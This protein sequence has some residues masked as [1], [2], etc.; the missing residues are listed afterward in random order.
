MVIYDLVKWVLL[1]GVAL[2]LGSCADYPTEAIPQVP[3]KASAPEFYSPAPAARTSIAPGDK[4]NIGSYFHPDLKQAVTVRPDGRV[5]LLLVGTVIAADKTPEF[6]AKELARAYGRYVENAEITVNVEESAALVV[7]VGGEV[8]KPT[9]LPIKGEL[10]LLQSITQAGGF[11][12]TANKEQVLIVRQTAYGGYRT[13]QANAEQVLHNDADEVYLRQH[14]VVFVPKSTI[15]K[16]DQ[17]V[18]QYLSQ[19]VPR[20]VFTTLGFGYQLN[21]VAGGGTTIVSPT[22]R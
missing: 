16:V 10:T 21:G 4:L 17:F 9:I 14:D 19:V 5:S 6:F 11:L 22:S 7:Y 13:L 18:D 3:N 1:L 15:A 8:A 20:W 12:S 2:T